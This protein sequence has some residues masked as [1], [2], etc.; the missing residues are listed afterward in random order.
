MS[1]R[2]TGR[3]KWFNEG[4]GYGFIERAK[5]EDVF[6][7]FSSVRGTGFKK[8]T[9]GQKVDFVVGQGEKGPQALDV[10]P[11]AA[12][13][14]QRLRDLNAANTAT[15]AAEAP[16]EVETKTNTEAEVEAQ[17]GSPAAEERS[18]VTE[19]EDASPVMAETP[20]GPGDEVV[21]SPPPAA[22][23]ASEDSADLG[24]EEAPPEVADSE[25]NSG[26]EDAPLKQEAKA[27]TG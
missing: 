7:H 12:E 3:V 27:E 17:V 21:D 13:I 6:V 2:E 15:A 10:G 23:D 20:A 16:A 9:E 18:V 19:V 5:G 22:A 25:A 14:P 1:E 8:L 4:K 11:A 26:E 24:E